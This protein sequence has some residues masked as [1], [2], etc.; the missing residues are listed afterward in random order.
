MDK[1]PSGILKKRKRNQDESIPSS[2]S[3]KRN[4]S[5]SSSIKT[6]TIPANNNK[7]SLSFYKDDD[8]DISLQDMSSQEE[9]ALDPTTAIHGNDD[10]DVQIR[11][12]RASRAVRRHTGDGKTLFDKNEILNDNDDNFQ[13]EEDVDER[14]SLLHDYN[15]GNSESDETNND[16]PI[17]PFNLKSERED[18][19]GYFDGDTYVFRRNRGEDGEDDAWVDTLDDDQN[20]DDSR[21]TGVRDSNNSNKL[22]QTSSSKSS[23]QRLES[24][25]FD[26]LTKESAYE[27]LIPLLAKDDETVMQALGR[28]GSIV[29]REKKQKIKESSSFSALNK[30]TELCNLFMM[31]FD[32]GGSIYDCTR[33]N[34][35]QFLH[36]SDA[37]EAMNRRK[38][39]QS[40]NGSSND[41]KSSKEQKVVQWEYK[42]NEDNKIHGPYSTEQMMQWINAGYFVG[43]M[44]VDLRI[45]GSDRCTSAR[46]TKKEETVDD[47]LGDLEDSDDEDTPKNAT[48]ADSIQS[49]NWLRSDQV[50]FQSYL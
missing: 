26:Q 1:Q 41:I 7:N 49:N 43:S 2:S 3:S 33:G 30:I 13:G 44:A 8:V 9:D 20:N 32:D 31:K 21:G 25:T 4:V 14:F 45:V 34:M 50:N 23:K 47:L 40:E 48:K 35:Q 19:M 17:E 37:I 18:G 27:Q 28:L 10:E 5:F 29:K 42:G 12:A 36:E 22:L 38:K 46:E 16:I 6:K 11:N 24:A 15:N 39:L